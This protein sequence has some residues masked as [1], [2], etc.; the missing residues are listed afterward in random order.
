[1]TDRE[2]YRNFIY[3]YFT[4]I[5]GYEVTKKANQGFFYIQNGEE[6]SVYSEYGLG[7]EKTLASIPIK[8][9]GKDIGILSTRTDF[10]VVYFPELRKLCIGRPKKIRLWMASSKSQYMIAECEKGITYANFKQTLMKDI[11]DKVIEI[12][13]G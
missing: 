5:L 8:N 11:F 7:K 12:K 4:T 10:Y 6:K 9:N 13:E 1:M 3:L 2:K